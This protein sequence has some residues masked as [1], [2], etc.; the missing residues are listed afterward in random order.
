MINYKDLKKKD[1][2][3]TT[4]LGTPITGKLLESPKQGKGLKST[5]LIWSNGSEI[6]MFDEAGSV[7]AHQVTEV[8]RDGKWHQVTGAPVAA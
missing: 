2:I 5:I 6:G 7:Y 1:M 8:N 4:Q 3:R